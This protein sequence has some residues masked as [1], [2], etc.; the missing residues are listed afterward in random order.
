MW[1]ITGISGF[2]RDTFM[3]KL[4]GNNEYRYQQ[5]LASEQ[6]FEQ[7][8]ERYSI[9]QLGAQLDIDPS[10]YD[11]MALKSAVVLFILDRRLTKASGAAGVARIITRLLLN[12][13]TGDLQNGELSTDWFHRLCEKLGHTK[14]DAF[15]RQWVYG[16]GCP[17]FKVNQRFN[18]K[19]LVVEMNIY[20]T[21]RERKIKPELQPSNF[22]REAKEQVSEVW[23]PEVSD[24]FTGPMTIRIHEADGTPYEH[25]VEIKDTHTKIEIPY[26]TK[27]KR[28]K[29]SKRAKE[30]AMATNGMELGGEAENDVLLY[31]LGDVLQSEDEV[32]DWRLVDWGKEE[33][34]RMGQESYEWIRMDAD[35]EWIGKIDLIM[36]I[37]MYVSQLQ[38][39]RDVVAQYEVSSRKLRVFYPTLTSSQSLQHVLKQNAH[40]L[41]STILVR[42]LMDRRYFHGI[43][44]LAAEGL[45]KCATPSL[46]WVGQYHLERAFQEFFCFADSPM[47]RANDF[48]DRMSYLL[49]KAIPIALSHVKDERGKVP[50]SVRRFFVDK[51]KFNDNSNNEVKFISQCKSTTH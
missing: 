25:I 13:K 11:F 17:L 23:A 34:D 5:K 27:Y 28:L 18:K 29:R 48:S 36:P 20:Q 37:Y 3:R 35:F 50:M 24:P 7:D 45:T 30:R 42:T 32:K 46:N 14:L 49:Q 38:Q 33:E 2:M 19:K 22:M 15:F 51:L 8:V 9:H 40:P 6:V 4:A 41:M 10:E 16:A 43:R 12:A 47:P 44:T 1:A 31:C 21:Q 26:N 39:D